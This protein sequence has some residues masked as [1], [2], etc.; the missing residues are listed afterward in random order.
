M[1]PRLLLRRALTALVLLVAFLAS[2][3]EALV[4]EL[5]IGHEDGIVLSGER[6]AS[7]DTDTTRPAPANTVHLCSC[8]HV[9][10][11]PAVVPEVTST[12]GPAVVPERRPLVG[13]PLDRTLLPPVPP[14]IA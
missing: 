11:R 4:C 7:D 13:A 2:S 8:T 6:P 9:V 14:P 1:R 12:L 3:T 10:V 5:E